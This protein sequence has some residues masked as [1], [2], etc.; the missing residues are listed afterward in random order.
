MMARP[1]QSVSGGGRAPVD[2]VQSGASMQEEQNLEMK[3]A[4][5]H[6]R[7]RIQ[8]MPQADGQ[9]SFG[10]ATSP[11]WLA[12]FMASLGVEAS[13]GVAAARKFSS[14][15]QQGSEFTSDAQISLVPQRTGLITASAAA[16]PARSG[17]ISMVFGQKADKGPQ[18]GGFAYGLPGNFNAVGDTELN[19]DP[20]GLLE[21]KTELEVNRYRECEITHGRVGML[22]SAGFLVQEKF[23][24]LFSG[25]G[26]PAIEQIPKLPVIM[27]PLIT[28]GIGA[29]EALRISV[30]WS[31]PNEPEHVFQKLRPEYVPG[32]IGFD[33]MGLKPTDPEEFKAMQT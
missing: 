17:N 13:V 15:G 28:I 25:D 31:N 14:H 11:G 21:G 23:H 26:G 33:P 2:A 24:P 27:W 5:Q 8:N 16:G 29:C 30:G 12:G 4:Y 19:W 6:L 20:L 9:A 3:V 18:N 22:A 1:R 32:D 10:S 7:A